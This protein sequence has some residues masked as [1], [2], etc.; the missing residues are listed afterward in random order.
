MLGISDS[1]PLSGWGRGKHNYMYNN[2]FIKNEAN[3]K[4]FKLDKLR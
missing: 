1:A 2:L 3:D 4:I